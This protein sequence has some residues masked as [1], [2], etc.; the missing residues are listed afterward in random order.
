M[1]NNQII[2]KNY[3][4]IKSICKQIVGRNTHYLDDLLQEVC[5]I[6][7]EMDNEKL[8]K[9]NNDSDNSI[10]RFTYMIINNQFNSKTSMFYRKFKK[11][12]INKVMEMDLL[13]QIL[14]IEDDITVTSFKSYTEYEE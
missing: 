3:I 8:N 13:D 10:I 14:D 5:L 1:T 2:D 11:Y 7:L 6:I 9:I 4:K 12:N